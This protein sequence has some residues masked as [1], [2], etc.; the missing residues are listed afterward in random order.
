MKSYRDQTYYEL[1]DLSPGASP[2]QV[3][4]A[5]EQATAIYAD[6]SIALN[7]LVTPEEAA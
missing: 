2:D 5:Y 4:A 1:L 7:S 3:K 6:D